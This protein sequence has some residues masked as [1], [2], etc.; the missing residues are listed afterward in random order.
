[1]VILNDMVHSYSDGM[2]EGNNGHYSNAEV[3]ELLG[4]ASVEN[5]M[6]KRAELVKKADAISR[7][8]V[9][10]LPLFF[11]DQIYGVRDGITY[12]PRA[13]DNIMAWDFEF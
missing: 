12:T 3:D 2:G 4:Q 8:E 13:G 9:G 10:Y 11:K 6:E 1:M 5:D 7:E